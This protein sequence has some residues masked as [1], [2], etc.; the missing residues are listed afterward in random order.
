[1]SNKADATAFLVKHTIDVLGGELKRL[2]STLE[3]L[4]SPQDH[5]NAETEMAK[6]AAAGPPEKKHQIIGWVR[7]A[8][9]SNGINMLHEKK[10]THGPR[11]LAI[12]TPPFR[13]EDLEDEDP[14]GLRRATEI[15]R[16]VFDDYS[17]QGGLFDFTVWV[18]AEEHSQTT[19]RLESILR[20]VQEQAQVLGLGMGQQ[21]PPDQYPSSSRDDGG[22][23]M[24]RLQQEI[25]RHLTGKK[26]LIFLADHSDETPWAQILPALPS[27]VTEESAIVLSP[28]VQQAYQY[29]GWYLLSLCFLR[30]RSRYRVYFYSHLFAT[31]NKAKEML[32]G[33]DN[34]GEDLHD[35]VNDI[36]ERCRWDSFS[37]KM[38]LHALY[39][40]HQRSKASLEN[41]LR[42][43][44]EFSTVNNARC[45]IKFCYD[46]LNHYRACFQYLSIFPLGFKI[47]RT[48]LVRRWAAEGIIV[49]RDGLAAADEAERCFNAM[50]DRGLLHPDDDNTDNPSGKVKMC[51]VHPHVLSFIA[52]LS[53]DDGRAADSIDLF[54]ALARRLSIASRIQLSNKVQRRVSEGLKMQMDSGGEPQVP[55]PGP[56][57]QDSV[58]EDMVMLLDLFPTTE[59]G[60]IKVLDLEGYRGLKKKHLKIICNKIFQL[61]Y[62]SLRNTD[63]AELPKEINKLQELETFDIRETNIDSFPAKS[64]VLP[65]LARLLSGV[66]HTH[67]DPPTSSKDNI[68]HGKDDKLSPESFTAIHIPRGIKNMTSMQ[69]L[70]H[71]QISDSHD[72]AAL[73]D[74]A[75]LQLLWKLGVII[76]GKQ[77]YLVLK[78]IGMLNESLRSLSIRLQDDGEVPDL[79]KTSKLFSP[80]VS[81]ASLSISGKIAGLPTW[82]QKLEQLS[83]ITM[84]DTSLKHSDVKILGDLLNLRFMR[85]L[86]ESYN[87]K[88]LTFEKGFK[89]L[90]ILIIERSST[91]SDVHFV[92]RV[93]PKLEKIV[94][95]ST[96]KM[97]NLGI[98]NLRGLKEIELKG[99]CDLNRIRQ[100]IKANPCHPNLKHTPI[101]NSSSIQPVTAAATNK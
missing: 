28:L 37:S 11:L 92:Q 99:N 34:G 44:D 95:S 66:G 14:R 39:V 17:R 67:T 16:R 93:A 45:M 12:V 56:R 54:P 8:L 52:W 88:E 43:L 64:I 33:G 53:K 19:A 98:H 26:F 23:E 101:L 22:G 73:E 75:R 72:K 25:R 13:R 85:L 78:V 61:K 58:L 82:L 91:I 29:V 36:L 94:W 6:E 81:L 84:C 83:D 47:R 51:K 80:P 50:I 48:S 79:N 3:E 100:S 89:N 49:G 15:A 55:G 62:L 24:T 31:R 7:R 40:N 77:A 86:G 70:S 71:V 5:H 32:R 63:V 76:H 1:M 21:P 97:E 38:F 4:I 46:D 68:S 74:L 30:R 27:D 90:E 18:N 57:P 69:I 42:H 2:L 20:Q 87:Q 35:P 96:C 65:K 60:W 10:D 9:K 41:L 59:S